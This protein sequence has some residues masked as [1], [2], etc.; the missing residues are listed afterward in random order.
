MSPRRAFCVAGLLFSV[1][2]LV[3]AQAPPPR[4]MRRIG[5]LSA[6]FVDSQRPYMEVFRAGMR[7]AGF[8]E[9][10]NLS[11]DIRYAEGDF[12]RLPA[13]VG[14]ML[15][16]S[17]EVLVAAQ[18][19][20]ALAAKRATAQVPIVAVS[21][22]DPVGV[23]LVESLARPGGNVT[24]VSNMTGELAGKR[25]EVLA[26]VLPGAKR[27]A[28]FFN[29]DD[30]VAGVQRTH[31]E[32]AA[33]SLGIDLD[34]F[35]PVRVLSDIDGAFAAAV[36]AGAN[37]ALRLVDPLAVRLRE[38]TVALAAKHRLPVM[39]AFAADV[40]AGGLVAF[41]ANNADLYRRAAALVVKILNGAKAGDLAVEQP[42][43]FDFAVNLKTARALGLRIPQ[44]VLLRAERVIE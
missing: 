18:T 29:P 12:Q 2:R 20:A 40:E 10:D 21:V 24:G 32:A 36:K 38:R 16:Q 35:L 14:D 5:V 17:P 8:M 1:Q 43:R 19:P 28:V 44:A 26:Q 39:F 31:A 7:E 34:P 22:G 37:A 41:G 30:P 6:S 9:G 42:T 33:R 11:L 15:R 27:V 25:L 23:G 4:R 13:M 3:G